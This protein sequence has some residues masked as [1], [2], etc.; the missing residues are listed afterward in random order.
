VTFQTASKRPLS[1][2]AHLG[3]AVTT[4]AAGNWQLSAQYDGTLYSNYT[5]NAASL[6]LRFNF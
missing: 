4:F 6:N 2:G 1:D 5:S 3:L